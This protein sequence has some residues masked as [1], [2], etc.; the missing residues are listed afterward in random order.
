MGGHGANFLDPN[1]SRLSLP[2]RYLLAGQALV[3][4][5]PVHLPSLAHVTVPPGVLLLNLI[6]IPTRSEPTHTKLTLINAPIA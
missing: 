6:A 3:E 4:T 5:M 1:Y 2:L